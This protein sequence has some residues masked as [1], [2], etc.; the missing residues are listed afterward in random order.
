MNDDRA[1]GQRSRAQLEAIVFGRGDA[2][3][4]A[5]RDA[6]AAELAR[7]EEERA[8]DAAVHE[9]DNPAARPLEATPSA[10]V[11]GTELAAEVGRP[12]G[13]ARW[14]RRL[15]LAGAAATA[16]LVAAVTIGM[17]V[18]GRLPFVPDD[19]LALFE[20]PQ[21]NEE[22]LYATRFG[23]PYVNVESFRFVQS[24]GGFDV[25]AYLQEPPE[26]RPNQDTLYCA[27]LDDGRDQII[28]LGCTTPDAFS[29]GPVSI[30]TSHNGGWV[31]AEWSPH[32]GVTV[33]TGTNA[34]IPPPLSIF[35]EEQD[36]AGL[37]AL[38]YLPDIPSSQQ[39]SLRFLGDSG[40]YYAAAYRGA[41]DDVCLAVYEAGTAVVTS[42][43]GCID[44]RTFEVEGIELAYPAADP[45]I[46][47]TWGP[48]PGLA[49]GGR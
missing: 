31:E 42:E 5:E 4:E 32:S 13:S 12:R 46:A 45:E 34:P 2:V 49:F 28:H 8:P 30:R 38:A 19:P 44:E 43:F 17:L 22:L 27:L 47:V 35:D 1:P 24:D 21:T 6:A 37:N 20:R 29:S 9:A 15:L 26:Q 16:V 18:T 7:L 3:T 48:G 10:D 11:P 33:T 25:Y 23:D 36:D 14:P 40:G 41:G 39:D